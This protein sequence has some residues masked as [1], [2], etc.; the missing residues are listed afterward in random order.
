[1]SS[2]PANCSTFESELQVARQVQASLLP[3]RCCL[4]NWT[5]AFSYE[6]A[7]AVGGDYVDLIPSQ[8]GAFHFA[9]GDVSGK[10]IAASMLMSHLHATLRA[11]LGSGMGIEQVM[12]TTSRIFC[13]SSLA[14]QFA[15]LVLGK[16]DQEGNV[17]L[18]NAGHTPV[19]LINGNEMQSIDAS[20]VPLG[21]FCATEFSATKTHVPPGSSLVIYSDGISEALDQAGNEFGLPQLQRDLQRHRFLTSAELVDKIAGTIDAFTGGTSPSD[22]RTLVVLTRL[23]A[24]AGFASS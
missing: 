8:N 16:A 17:E 13:E 12:R 11:L 7:A 1:M 19:L 22:D 5:F 18:V 3:S 6:P 10:G 24:A 21:L 14:A 2:A 9:L 23:S 15:T 20:N 4:G